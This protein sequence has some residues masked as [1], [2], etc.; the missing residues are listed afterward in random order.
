MK[1]KKKRINIAYYV[2]L[3]VLLIFLGA[4][5]FFRKRIGF[6]PMG[7]FTEIAELVSAHK[8]DLLLSQIASSFLVIS[9]LTLLSNKG[10]NVLWVDIIEYKL[11]SPARKSFRDITG[12]C[13]FTLIFSFLA[14][15]PKVP[16]WVL[17][18][19]FLWNVFFLM[20]MTKKMIEVFYDTKGIKDQLIEEYSNADI[21]EKKK[22]LELLT[23][24][25]VQYLDSK[26]RDKVR[27]NVYFLFCAYHQEDEKGKGLIK[28]AV[29]EILSDVPPT[30]SW[31]YIYILDMFVDVV[32]VEDTIKSFIKRLIHDNLGTSNERGSL[33]HKL[34]Y[35]LQSELDHYLQEEIEAICYATATA[36]SRYQGSKRDI[37][38]EFKTRYKYID[39]L[40]YAYLEGDNEMVELIVQEYHNLWKKAFLKLEVYIEEKGYA[41]CVDLSMA[42]DEIPSDIFK[43]TE[44]AIINNILRKEAKEPILSPDTCKSMK[45]LF[46]QDDL[47]EEVLEP[48][49]EELEIAEYLGRK[50]AE[51]SWIE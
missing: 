41:D 20:W 34:F 15:I 3:I 49:D 17:L 25:T 47:D 12:Y 4:V 37:E 9:L 6:D 10:E 38:L 32:K 22:C 19:F 44:K 46:L 43:E 18:Y 50:K 48:T 14:M 16:S 35:G 11:I 5:D 42:A 26:E 7:I 28:E 33:I 51:E 1:Q 45:A 27:E 8:V 13:F 2:G 39:I 31:A 24:K 23:E 36:N 40:Q 21:S 29:E 30:E